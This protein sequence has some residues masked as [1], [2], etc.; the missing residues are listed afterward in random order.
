MTHESDEPLNR[1]DCHRLRHML[2]A[3]RQATEFST[4]REKDALSCDAMY[5]RAIVSCLQEI[6]EAAVRI[7]KP[8]R[9]RVAIPWKQII[10]MRNQL[11]HVYFDVNWN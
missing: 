10:G 3:A 6:G 7:S 11:V 5:R 2:E 8:T 1:A 4:G 9:M